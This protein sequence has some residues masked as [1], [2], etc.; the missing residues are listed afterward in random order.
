MNKK[1]FKNLIKILVL[2]NLFER[3]LYHGTVVDNEKSISDLGLF[4]SVGNF[5][6]QMYDEEE[7][8]F[9]EDEQSLVY[10]A[11]KQSLKKSLNAITAQVGKKLNK[12]F[13]DVTV[14]DIRNHGLLAVIKTGDEV[15]TKAPSGKEY[16]MK[17]GPHTNYRFLEPDD[18]Y[19]AGSVGVDYFLKGSKLINFFKRHGLS[20]ATSQEKREE[21][22]HLAKKAHPNQTEDA[23]RKA[24]EN[25]NDRSLDDMLKNYKK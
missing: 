23:I 16:H 17:Y 15:M 18:W 21:L 2:E 24:I 10:A 4:P 7:S 1:K 14:N 8:D 9:D 13:H 6:K 25:V 11:D 3:T 5:I 20:L 22:F 12:N 19:S